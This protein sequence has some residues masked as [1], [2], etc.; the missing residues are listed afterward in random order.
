MTASNAKI[1]DVVDWRE[2]MDAEKE[3]PAEDLPE[4]GWSVTTKLALEP[5]GILIEAL[6]EPVQRL[7][8]VT[9]LESDGERRPVLKQSPGDLRFCERATGI[10]F[11]ILPAAKVPRVSKHHRGA[12]PG[13]GHRATPRQ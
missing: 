1:L 6:G 3:S 2:N 7:L 12:K 5:I 4:I 9:Q 11:R 8:P 13:C 10:S